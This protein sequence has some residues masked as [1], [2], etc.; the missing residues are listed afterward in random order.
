MMTSRLLPL[1]L[2]QQTLSNNH[3]IQQQANTPSTAILQTPLTTQ[4]T[5]SE[6]PQLQTLLSAADIY[7]RFCHSQP[8]SLFHEAT[9]RQRLA[10]DSL[11]TYLLWGFLS[12]ARRYSSLSDSQGNT[13]D[14][15]STYAAKAWECI[16]LPWSGSAP[17]QKV[18][19]V[20]QTIILIVSTEVPGE[21]CKNPCSISAISDIS[22][23]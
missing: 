3:P 4:S 6:R 9:F 7:F 21:L 22:I 18:L 15:A 2:N 23:V 1:A 11:P 17:P 14:D 8:Y 10:D 13:A 5:A 12:A 16:D 19:T 20:V